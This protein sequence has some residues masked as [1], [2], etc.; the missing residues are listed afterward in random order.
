MERGR[1]KKAEHC[2]YLAGITLNGTGFAGYAKRV[3]LDHGK[4]AAPEAGKHLVGM[5]RRYRG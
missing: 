5:V 2:R 4:H 1:P 3:R